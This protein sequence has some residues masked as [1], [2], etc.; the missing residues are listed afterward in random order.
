M[1]D[2]ILN[3]LMLLTVAAALGVSIRSTPDAVPVQSSADTWLT[4]V[5][6]VAAYRERRTEQRKRE[7]EA[8]AVLLADESCD[9]ALR[10]QARETLLTMQRCAETEQIAE[11]LAIGRGYGDTVCTLAGETLFFVLQKPIAT[12]DA[13]QLIALAAQATGVSAE[14]VRIFAG[15]TPS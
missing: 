11:A 9:A 12:A 2:R 13:A 1:K 4:S 5:D 8:L 3:A 7:E 10:A 14:N 6:P 15:K